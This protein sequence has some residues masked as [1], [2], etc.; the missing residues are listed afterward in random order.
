MTT[1]LIGI[2]PLK[3][4]SIFD[5]RSQLDYL[6]K[7]KW[8][9]IEH[10]NTPWASRTPLCSLHSWSLTGSFPEPSSRSSLMASVAASS[11]DSDLERRSVTNWEETESTR[12]DGELPVVIHA[13]NESNSSAILPSEMSPEVRS[14]SRGLS[15][16]SKSVTPS[17]LSISHSFGRNEDD[18]DLLMY[19]DSELEDH[20]VIQEE[21]EKGNLIVDKSWEDYAS[22]EFTMI[23]SKAM[24]NGPKAMLEAKVRCA[25]TICSSLHASFHTLDF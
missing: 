4:S 7:L 24:K 8:P 15:L 17:K 16:I 23:L 5:Y 10:K 13:E 3:F 9:R 2:I 21:T 20:P 19:S 12:E 25:L 6:T 18:L 1:C 14:H 22:K 11:V